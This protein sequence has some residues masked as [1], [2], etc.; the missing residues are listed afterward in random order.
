MNV[1]INFID[2]PTV[3]CNIVDSSLGRS[4]REKG[5]RPRTWVR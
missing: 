5:G 1:W 3:L 2:S 4:R